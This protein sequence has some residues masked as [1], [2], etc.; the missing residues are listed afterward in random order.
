M[1]DLQK[2]INAAFA[3]ISAIPVTGEDQERAVMAKEHLRKAYKMAAPKEIKKADEAAEA[4]MPEK[5]G[6]A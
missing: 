3:A 6:L 1:T 4:A 5:D 2:E